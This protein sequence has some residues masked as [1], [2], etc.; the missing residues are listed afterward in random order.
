[1]GTG[2]DGF[3]F[4]DFGGFEDFDLVAEY[5]I[6]T[7]GD[8]GIH[9]RAPKPRPAR[10][11]RWG[12]LV[13]GM[14]AEISVRPEAGFR[15]GALTVKDPDVRVLAKSSIPPHAA[16][17]WTRM[18][19]IARK[20]RIRILVD[21]QPV[22]DYTDTERKFRRGH[23]AL[24][25]WE[26]GG[27]KTEVEFR[28]LDVRLLPEEPPAPPAHSHHEAIQ[29]T[30]MGVSADVQGQRVPELVFKAVGPSIA[31]AG[32]KVTWKADPTPEARNVFAALA[33]FSLDGVFHLDPT[34][35]PKAIDLTVL[36]ANPRTPVGTPAPRALLGIY[37]LDGDTLELCVAIDP[38][39]AEE[40]P[41]TFASA[42][43]KFIAHVKLRRQPPP[44]AGAADPAVIQGLR[45]LVA[46]KSRAQEIAQIRFEAGQTSGLDDVVAKIELIEARVRLAEAEGDRAA[47]A[48]LLQDLVA[49]REEERR[50]IAALVDVGRAPPDDLHRADARLAEAKTWL[51]RARPAAPAKPPSDPPKGP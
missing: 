24:S 44:A 18:E 48:S 45:D 46:A 26:G 10:G 43:G 32:D 25:T 41:T 27:I 4:T 22:T 47:V 1:M 19:L 28:K 7:S 35:S 2:P 36:G 14:E 3:L 30:W 31:F 17:E 9:F 37:K 51:A 33:R 5:R 40:R 13:N 6:N 12:Y 42:P 23:L 29:G 39:H 8:S 38:E 11:T 15:T 50:L 21:D 49:R 34:K 16:G 20:D